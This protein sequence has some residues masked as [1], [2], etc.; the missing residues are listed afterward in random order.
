[1]PPTVAIMAG[2]IFQDGT[3][4]TVR[5]KRV[6]TND[7]IHFSV[8]EDREVTGFGEMSY[9]V[10][11]NRFTRIVS[12]EDACVRIR[13]LGYVASRRVRIYGEEFEL[14]SD[15][16]PEHDRIVIRARAKGES[17]TRILRL[18]VTI[19]QSSRGERSFRAA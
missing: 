12:V 13:R 11:I 4:L 9:S 19:I 16:F 15:P 1:M 14:L 5:V 10:F 3:G 2:Q 8:V 6:D 18:P 17:S 7:R